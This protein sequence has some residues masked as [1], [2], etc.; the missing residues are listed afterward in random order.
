MS[1]CGDFARALLRVCNALLLALGLTMCGVS[2]AFYAR[3]QQAAGP[4]RS[5]AALLV[6]DAAALHADGVAAVLA[7][8][9][10]PWCVRAHAR[11]RMRESAHA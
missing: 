4:Q 7:S 2:A 9:P 1:A 5:A 3:W 6:H 11:T 8:L 10:T